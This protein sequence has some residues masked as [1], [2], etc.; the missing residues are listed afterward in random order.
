M[1]SA[2]GTTL[3]GPQDF[4]LDDGSPFEV[5]VAHERAWGWDYLLPL[6]N[7]LKLDPI[8]CQIYPAGGGGGVSALF[9]VPFYQYG[10]SGLA[11][12]EPGQRLYDT[13]QTPPQLIQK[14]TANFAG[15]NVPDIS[16][17]SDPDTGY[18]AYYTSDQTGF[19][20]NDF[21][22]GTS[23]AA[24]QMNGVT[25]LIDQ[26]LGHR[27]GLL[28]FPLYGLV[29]AGRAYGGSHPPLRDITHGDNWFYRGAAGYDPATGVGVPN[30][31]NLVNVL[32]RAED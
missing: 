9:P 4:V 8:A 14:L 21:W 30:V 3:P 24:P 5:H 18:I 27:V 15:R 13:S 29:R 25:S 28:N 10:I 23:F 31:A 2:G 17:N 1:T 32:Q 7:A 12:T 19:A 16:V 11:T 22:G 26:A 6:C 20:V